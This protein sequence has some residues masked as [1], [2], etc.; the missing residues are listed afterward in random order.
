MTYKPILA[1]LVFLL[2][3][4]LGGI[5]LGAIGQTSPTAISQTVILTGLLSVLIIY[6][7]GLTSGKRLFTARYIQW[8]LAPLALIGTL[9]GIIATDFV[10]ELLNLPDL[11][12]DQFLSMARTPWGICGIAI[13]SPI[14]EEIVFREAVLGHLL[15]Q[16]VRPLVAILSSALAFG[17]IHG[18]PVQIPFATIVGILFAIIYYKTGSIL[19]TSLLHI[20]N[21]SIAVAQMNILGDQ[22]LDFRYTDLLG[23]GPFLATT[24][25]LSLLSVTLMKR[26]WDKAPTP[27]LQA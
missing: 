24:L 16:G 25:L 15:R 19:L 22:A 6:L 17:L 5:L 1:I 9:C 21:N 4:A 13:I 8:P 7:M 11:M 14:V 10:S 18:N 26:F 12:A 27:T 3:Q 2:L 23:T 20:I